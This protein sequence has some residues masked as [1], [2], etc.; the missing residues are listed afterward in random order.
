MHDLVDQKMTDHLRVCKSLPPTTEEELKERHVYFGE[1]T[2]HKTLIF[3]LDET[4]IHAEI[5]GPSETRDDR[6]FFIMLSGT[7]G[8]DEHKVYV[9]QRPYMDSL[10]EHMAKLYEIAVFTAATQ[11]YADKIIDYI[12][13]QNIVKHRL[14]RQH[15]I[16]RDDRY[17]VKDL[18]IV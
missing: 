5:V 6:S 14:Y 3:D 12:D 8:E 13:P 2:R 17:Y 11:E 4:L 18:R 15:C 9:K 16:V 1:H 10:L 7:S